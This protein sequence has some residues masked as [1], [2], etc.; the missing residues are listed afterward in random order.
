MRTLLFAQNKFVLYTRVH[1]RFSFS[2]LVELI[3]TL[4][5][6]P[7]FF[8]Q[9]QVICPIRQM[10]LKLKYVFVITKCLFNLYD[11]YESLLLQ[12]FLAIVNHSTAIA[13]RSENSKVSTTCKLFKMAIYDF[14]TLLLEHSFSRINIKTF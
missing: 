5:Y 1:E 6:F 7:Y 3:M 12:V 10:L 2:S 11:L 8:F 13:E 14:N 4:S 9:I